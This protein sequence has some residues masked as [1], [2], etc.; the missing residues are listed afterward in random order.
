[1][2]TNLVATITARNQQEAIICLS[3]TLEYLVNMNTSLDK[4]VEIKVH[5]NENGVVYYAI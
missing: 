1:M 2:D 4:P 5:G 3:E